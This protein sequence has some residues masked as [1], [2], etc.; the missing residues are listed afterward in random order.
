MNQRSRRFKK[1]IAMLDGGKLNSAF[2]ILARQLATSNL[3]PEKIEKHILHITELF[4]INRRVALDHYED[5]ATLKDNVAG[6]VLYLQS[7]HTQKHPASINPA[8]YNESEII[9]LAS[10]MIDTHKTPHEANPSTLTQANVSALID[11]EKMAT[12]NELG[13]PVEI[14]KIF[15]RVLACENGVNMLRE[16]PLLLRATVRYLLRSLATAHPNIGIQLP[17]PDSLAQALSRYEAIP[18]IPQ[19]HHDI[20][21]ICTLCQLISNTPKVLIGTYHA[22]QAFLKCNSITGLIDEPLIYTNLSETIDYSMA[23]AI[24]GIHAVDT[25]APALHIARCHQHILTLK[26]A[27][28]EPTSDDDWLTLGHCWMDAENYHQAIH[29]YRI[30]VHNKGGQKTEKDDNDR[31]S[32]NIRRSQLKEYNGILGKAYLKRAEQYLAI[33]TPL[34]NTDPTSYQ[35]YITNA[36]KDARLA[37]TLLP[38][39]NTVGTTFH[40]CVTQRFHAPLIAT[41]VQLSDKPSSSLANRVVLRD[42]F[43]GTYV[44]TSDVLTR[45]DTNTTQNHPTLL[46]DTNRIIRS[47]THG[48]R[49]VAVIGKGEHR[50]HIKENPSCPG[51]EYAVGLLCELMMGSQMGATPCV[52]PSMA[53]RLE[54]YDASG[55]ISHHQMVQVSKT[56]E[57]EP[58]ADILNRCGDNEISHE[59]TKLNRASYSA[60]VVLSLLSDPEDWKAD[61]LIVKKVETSG[62]DYEYHI[63]GIDNDHAFLADPIDRKAARRKDV[64]SGLEV[65]NIVYCLPDMALTV[66]DGLVKQVMSNNY[67]PIEL[68]KTWGM[69]INHYNTKIFA[70]VP[71]AERQLLYQGRS[72]VDRVVL[73]G[74]FNP[75]VMGYLYYKFI[76]LRREICHLKLSG[77][78]ITHVALLSALHRELWS[79][80]QTVLEQNKGKNPRCAFGQLTRGEFTPDGRSLTT[81]SG[82]VNRVVARKISYIEEI[83]QPEFLP[84]PEG[85]MKEVH[86]VPFDAVGLTWAVADIKMGNISLFRDI[87][88]RLKEQVLE[89]IDF[90]P[91]IHQGIY[92]EIMHDEM[93]AILKAPR[94]RDEDDETGQQGM[95]TL[96]LKNNTRLR[97][98]LGILSGFIGFGRRDLSDIIQNNPGLEYVNLTGCENISDALKNTMLWK[99]PHWRESVQQSIREQMGMRFIGV[100]EWHLLFGED[101]IDIPLLPENIQTQLQVPCPFDETNTKKVYETHILFLLP[102]QLRGTPLTILE[103]NKILT[104]KDHNSS[105]KNGTFSKGDTLWQEQRFA[106]KF[107]PASKW[108]LMPKTILTDSTN[109]TWKEQIA[110]MKQH[111]AAYQPIEALELAIGLLVYYLQTGEYL[112]PKLFARTANTY[113]ITSGGHHVDLG[114]FGSSGLVVSAGWDGSRA[115]TLGLG[116]ARYFP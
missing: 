15:L 4:R 53:M 13:K 23:I 73:H 105:Y 107:I 74:F 52:T 87:P 63:V 51:L 104:T 21:T 77:T 8:S 26:N 34:L 37:V 84:T 93:M 102:V 44:L 101:I 32:N 58:L 50:L 78:P 39:H 19:V 106:T 97:E 10:S 92:T 9:A 17:I 72:E 85:I 62:S 81:A 115:S 76:Q 42:P 38:N 16:I 94:G 86:D 113:N 29:A 61:N 89:K 25:A 46:D 82:M 6:I 45:K 5:I 91:L 95:K 48:R 30:L 90:G 12:P 60:L 68:L 35:T 55:R 59:L 20:H 99:L 100:N 31:Y 22:V 108:V 70:L 28:G 14:A 40:R 43:G 110:H 11:Y 69:A 111:Y 49:N 71:L 83:E 67:N 79:V 114:Y 103:W 47:N 2:N 1:H 7:I 56:V 33:A 75:S 66:D 109:K 54:T 98:A 64:L 18:D 57:G 3:S 27:L 41:L 116:V 80:Y 24:L 96:T 36:I 88:I 65:K 112:I